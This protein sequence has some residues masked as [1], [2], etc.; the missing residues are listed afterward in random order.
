MK[1]LKLSFIIFSVIYF[2]ENISINAQD[3]TTL[4]QDMDDLMLAPQDKQGT[5]KIVLTNLKSGKEKVRE[6]EMKQKGR[7]YRLYRYTQPEKQAGIAT[8]SL[9]DNVMWMYMPAFA[10]PK[11]NITIG[12]KP[13]F[14]RD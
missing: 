7:D 4:L 6:A 5:V 13:G 14:Y 1:I 10:K 12:Q 2:T 8:L 3:A 9:P 11:K